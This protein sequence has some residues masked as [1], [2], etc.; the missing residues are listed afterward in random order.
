M[1]Y[2]YSKEKGWVGY[3]DICE[4]LFKPFI[5]DISITVGENKKLKHMTDADICKKRNMNG[6]CEK[7]GQEAF[8]I[9]SLKSSKSIV[10][11]II[12]GV[13]VV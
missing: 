11:K 12:D 2:K 3:C 6:L 13:M 1:T 4:S 5:I 9:K 7:C 10:M 8:D